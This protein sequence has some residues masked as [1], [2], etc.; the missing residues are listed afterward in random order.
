MIN[1]FAVLILRLMS[2]WLIFTRLIALVGVSV[3]QEG[4]ATLY[5]IHGITLLLAALIFW[6]SASLGRM[7]V[8]GLPAASAATGMDSPALLHVG[9]VLL[10]F[11]WVMASLPSVVAYLIDAASGA[12]G[13]YP[14][15]GIITLLLSVGLILGARKLS[16][17]GAR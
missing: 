7:L 8:S 4:A 15:T 16:Q 17:T 13:P 5:S 12:A 2:A 10:G 3:M 9:T 14:V 11:Y 6:K 1:V